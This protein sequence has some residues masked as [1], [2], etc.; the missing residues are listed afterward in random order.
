MTETV[1]RRPLATMESR[2]PRSIRFC[3]QD[4]QRL[5]VAARERGVEA[6][7]LARDCCL[8]G[9]SILLDPVLLEEHV[10]ASS[11]LRLTHA[12]PTR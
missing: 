5:S 11:R 1:P 7:A 4:W 2:E 3:P 9:L 6:S 8:M 12:G 10:R